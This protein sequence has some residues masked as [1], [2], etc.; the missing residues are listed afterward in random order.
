MRDTYLTTGCYLIERL[1][2]IQD[3]DNGQLTPY[4]DAIASL[5]FY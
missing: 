4:H 5:I 1:R 2:K 3:G